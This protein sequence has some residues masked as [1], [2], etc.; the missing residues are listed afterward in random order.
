MA[1]FHSY[2]SNAPNSRRAVQACL[3]DG[4][5]SVAP[6]AVFF[7]AT[8]GHNFND[9][10]DSLSEALPNTRVFG[11]S[12]AG[13]VVPGAFDE[14][15][16]ALAIMAIDDLDGHLAV[17]YA[18]AIDGRSSRQ[19]GA[20]LGAEL[21]PSSPRQLMVYATGIDVSGDQL[22]AGLEGELGDIPVF[23]G[24]ASDNMQAIRCHQILDGTIVDRGVLA[25]GFSDPAM[26]MVSQATHG[27]PA[28]GEPCTVTRSG[29]N[30][31]QE[32]DGQ[33]AWNWF[34]SRLELPESSSFLD[35]IP[36]GAL[37]ESLPANAAKAYDN[38]HI[39]R[40]I[41]AR[42]EDGSMVYP[43][44]CP[45]GTRLWLTRRDEGHIFKKT[46]Q[47]MAALV[48]EI[49]ERRPVAVFHADCG[50]RGRL[51]FGQVHKEEL[52]ACMQ[53]PVF[54]VAPC[55]WLGMYGL[56]EFAPL[57]GD[58]AFHNYSTALGILIKDG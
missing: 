43:V 7:H 37:A 6:S 11:C 51:A 47:T 23:G 41:S 18:P 45:V 30:V 10:V 1:E 34:T 26:S 19:I 49:G 27:F 13:V 31:I 44:D 35:T 9:L 24:Y 16:Q 52:I 17:A 32:I 46:E 48:A 54:E 50:A 36:I 56:G 28:I 25:F 14:S 8:I 3:N 53:D 40:V 21:A 5:R 39:L 15:M 2:F 29:G 38:P 33:P 22:L 12:C 58:N 4:L 57:N 42:H 55:A 20:Q